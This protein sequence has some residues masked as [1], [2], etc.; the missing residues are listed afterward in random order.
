MGRSTEELWL[1]GRLNLIQRLKNSL[2]NWTSSLKKKY[3][4]LN[5]DVLNLEHPKVFGKALRNNK[6]GLWRYRVDKFR[7]ICKLEE[8]KLI[9]LVVAVAKRDIVYED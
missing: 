1:I 3:S 7:I 9:I 2:I 8:D 4:Y 6:K 5:K